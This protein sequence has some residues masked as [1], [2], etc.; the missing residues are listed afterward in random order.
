LQIETLVQKRNAAQENIKLL[1]AD[2]LKA[3]SDM[4]TRYK[5]AASGVQPRGQVSGERKGI[6]SDSQQFRQATWQ[7]SPERDAASPNQQLAAL[8]RK[9][10]IDNE[11]AV[12][13]SNRNLAQDGYML[14]FW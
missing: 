3:R 14:E 11:V 12:A 7:P 9:I 8:L 4:D 2:L 5:D 10:A 6:P 1:A 13:I